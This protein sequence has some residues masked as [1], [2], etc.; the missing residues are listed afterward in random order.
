VPHAEWIG[1]RP[2]GLQ[3]G[4][5]LFVGT[6]GILIPGVQPVVLAALLAEQHITLTQLGHAASV[7]L[8]SMGLA[9][10]FAAAFLPP[11]RL[12]AIA[13]ITSLVLAAGN[14]F[15]PF[16]VGEM[17]TAVRAVT[18]FTGGILIWVAAC[19]IARSAAP[20]RWAGIYLTVQ[21][22]T[23]LLFVAAM[24]AWAEPKWG[25]QG[26][27][28]MLAVASLASGAAA[29]LLPRAFVPLPKTGDLP[30]GGLPPPLGVAGLVV[31]F[32]LM[33]FIVSIWVYYDPI[34]REAGLSS[35]VS[36]TAVQVSLGFRV[37]GGTAATLFAGRLRWYPTLLA[38][39][40][41]DLVMVWILGTR[42]TAV[43]FF[44]DAAIFGFIWLFIL[45]FMVPMLIEADPSR[46]AAVLCSGVGL[47]GGS[48][49]PTV[50]ALLISPENTSGALWLGAG[51]LVACF[52]IA[53][54]LRMVTRP[55][56]A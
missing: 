9:A 22:L 18:G 44:A 45:P 48:I 47:L 3:I 4:M 15:T 41:V 17:V 53:T 5:I 1:P 11:R 42:P 27:F 38:C 43:L 20:D 32:L 33:M 6:I 19:M 37:L 12:P 24:S 52:A 25:A 7:E 34:A 49:G 51:C 50:A 23:Q 10:A 40:V 16:A 36:D 29:L 14:W 26:D 13:L 21:T 35:K 39:A 30:V 8:L 54:G 28:L 31:N 55:R 46:R 56:A 2:A